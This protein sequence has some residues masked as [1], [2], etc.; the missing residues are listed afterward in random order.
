VTRDD[1]LDR[2]GWL[3]AGGHVDISVRYGRSR[4]LPLT[5]EGSMP[6]KVM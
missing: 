6:P 1:G 4:L 2:V 3:F 5:T